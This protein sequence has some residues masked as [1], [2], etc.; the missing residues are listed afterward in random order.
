MMRIVPVRRIVRRA[1]RAPGYRRL[2]RKVLTALRQSDLAREIVAR[3]FGTPSA[4]RRALPQSYPPAGNVIAGY[5][6]DH[7]PVVVIVMIDV[8]QSAIDGIIDD[9]ARLQILG[10]GFR[11]VIVLD[12]PRLDSVRRFGYAV[13]LVIAQERWIREQG[14]W[15]SYAAQRLADIAQRYNAKS[16][17]AITGRSL[18]DSHWVL[19]SSLAEY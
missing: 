16:T 4:R 18:S 6:T 19:L 10:A 3:V 13:E 11:P 7:L 17:L 15:R 8:D 14:D 2:R 9:I 1:R 12:Q 5:G